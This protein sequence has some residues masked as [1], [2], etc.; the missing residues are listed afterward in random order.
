MGQG[1]PG[2][3]FGSDP[4]FAKNTPTVTTLTSTGTQ[5]GR[6]TRPRSPQETHRRVSENRP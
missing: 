3:L 4:S 1:I 2:T 5:T 6:R